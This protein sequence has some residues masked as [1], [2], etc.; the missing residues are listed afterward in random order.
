[1][2][3]NVVLQTLAYTDVETW[4]TPLLVIP[5]PLLQCNAVHCLKGILNDFF[6]VLIKTEL[7]PATVITLLVLICPLVFNVCRYSKP[8][9]LWIG[10]FFT[11]LM[12]TS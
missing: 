7:K 9:N 1:M 5:I 4:G 10:R 8:L 11:Q 6:V 12:I 2:T 3:T